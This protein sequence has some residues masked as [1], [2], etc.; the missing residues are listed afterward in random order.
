[1]WNVVDEHFSFPKTGIYVLLPKKE[2][3][4]KV[5]HIVIALSLSVVVVVVV[6]MLYHWHLG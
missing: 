5:I 1:V 4:R 2:E 3:H 6:V